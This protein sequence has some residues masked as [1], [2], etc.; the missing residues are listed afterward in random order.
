MIYITGDTHIPTDIGK[1]SGKRFPEQKRL[2]K[3]DYVIICGDFGGV[4]DNSNEEKYWIKWLGERN[5]TTLFIDGNHENFDMI[6]KLPVINFCGGKARKVANGIYHLL[7]GQVFEID[8]KKIFVFGGASSHDK[9]IRTEGKNWWREEL[10]TDIEY[11]EAKKNIERN[12]A[13][14]DYILTHCCP[15]SVQ[16]SI[17]PSYEVNRLT[18]FFDEVK[19]SIL[20][21]KWF[22]GHYHK[23][24]E[25]EGNFVG[26]FN[27]IIQL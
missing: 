27:K 3:E 7:R 9:D 6:N 25:L 22:F 2:S 12:E 17:A 15:T 18:D 26:V 16:Q 11:E 20:Y 8:K 5:F 23:D 4:W 14:F 1:L 24:I 19:D 21:Q 10:P 13:S